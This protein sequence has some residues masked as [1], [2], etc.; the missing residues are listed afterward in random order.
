MKFRAKT[1]SF[2]AVQWTGKNVEEI[3]E[4]IKGDAKIKHCLAFENGD[5]ALIFFASAGMGLYTEIVKGGHWFHKSNSGEISYYNPKYFEKAYEPIEEKSTAT[6]TWTQD[7]ETF[8]NTDC[9]E[10]FILEDGIPSKHQFKYCCFC[11]RV[12]KEVPFIEEEVSPEE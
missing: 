10:I 1:I 2:E 7:E 9:E 4:F 3:K 11:G 5:I 6:C 12:L 8:W